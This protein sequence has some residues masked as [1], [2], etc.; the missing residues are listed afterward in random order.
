MALKPLE[1]PENYP[2]DIR[3]AF[4]SFEETIKEYRTK[5]TRKKFYGYWIWEAFAKEHKITEDK[6]KKLKKTFNLTGKDDAPMV[7]AGLLDKALRKKS[8]Y[9]YIVELTF[10]EWTTMTQPSK[11]NFLRWMLEAHP[12]PWAVN[13]VDHQKEKCTYRLAFPTLAD[14]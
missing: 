6:V 2:P 10:L 8:S 3:W 9:K 7:I 4:I 14:L 5:F 1:E 11:L 12:T 13:E